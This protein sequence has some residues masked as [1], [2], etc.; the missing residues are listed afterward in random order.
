MRQNQLPPNLSNTQAPSPHFQ[1][2]SQPIPIAPG[3]VILKI[4]IGMGGHNAVLALR[5]SKPA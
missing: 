2:P 1:A 4:A 3:S 5:H